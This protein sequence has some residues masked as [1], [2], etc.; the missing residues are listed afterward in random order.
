MEA[1]KPKRG[2]H[3][4]KKD[5]DVL[6]MPTKWDPLQPN[7]VQVDISGDSLL[8]LNWTLSKWHPTDPS[9]LVAVHSIVRDMHDWWV[10]RA[11]RPAQAHKEFFRHHYRELNRHADAMASEGLRT[12]KSRVC[13]EQ[14][15]F[16][17]RPSRI[18]AQ[19]DG[20]SKSGLGAAGF[21]VKIQDGSDEMGDPI[22]KEALRG[23]QF[24]NFATVTKA[25]LCGAR[26]V[27]DVISSLLTSKLPFFDSGYEMVFATD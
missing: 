19:F 4:E 6:Y 9:H 14:S 15:A 16:G 24:L 2:G 25:E 22:W 26:I 27:C 11:A 20:G 23:Y 1:A 7:I 3:P 21:V 13:I 5:R 18:W 10:D 17:D 8:I 12:R